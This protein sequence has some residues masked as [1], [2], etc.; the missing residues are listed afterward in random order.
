MK[1]NLAY[2]TDLETGTNNFCRLGAQVTPP[3]NIIYNE[4]CEETM[5]R[6]PDKSIQ[7]IIA[8]PPYYKIKGE[9]DW[10][11]KTFE[12]YLDWMETL[13]V[14][15]KRILADNGSLFVYSHV[16][17]GSYVQVVFDKYFTLENN[18]RWQKRREGLYGSSGSEQI[19]SFPPCSETILFYSNEIVS[20]NGLCVNNT[21]DYIRNEIQRAKGKI[22]FKEVNAALG[23]ATNGGGVASAVLSLDKAE[24]AMITEESYNKLREW[25]N[26]GKDYEYLR[27]DYEDLRKDFEDLR[28]PF[29]NLG[30]LDVIYFDN[31]QTQN[32]DIKHETV[33]PL[34]LSKML[35]TTC[36]REKDL[37]YIPFVGSGTECVAV[38]ELN[39]KFIGSEIN[40]K[41]VEIAEARIKGSRINYDLFYD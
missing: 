35:V 13:A 36:S 20:I 19:R 40:P 15:F 41:Y 9:F 30:Y 21:R 34:T 2:K 8:D 1:D 16:K 33:K 23:T 3:T 27:K 31:E 28:R 18:I 29:R 4:E 6:L 7:L 14:E 25:L 38:N 5:K 26:G 10:K 12:E 39:R 11:W 32:K 17:N 22:I 24:P 37:V